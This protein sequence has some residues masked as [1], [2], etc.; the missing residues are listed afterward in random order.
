MTNTF[1]TLARTVA[2]GLPR[3]QVLRGMV[4]AGVGVALATIGRSTELLAD[5][6]RRAKQ[7]KS[8]A[9]VA[10]VV[11]LPGGHRPVLT[12]FD[13]RVGRL[14]YKG[15]NLSL[16]PQ[17]SDVARA[18]ELSVYTGAKASTTLRT[19]LTLPLYKRRQFDAPPTSFGFPEAPDIAVAA[20]MHDDMPVFSTDNPDLD[21][22]VS[23]CY[24]GELSC[25]ACCCRAGDPSCGS[26][27]D[28]G[29]CPGCS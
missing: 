14:S 2:T 7:S 24:G 11:H 1:D 17:I 12:L 8:V 4:G 20:L 26:C 19:R 27:C 15:Q 6:Q 29:H 5:E 22:T 21:C 13:R 3:R 25:Q 10:L 23:C 28:A 9:A 18:V 16:V